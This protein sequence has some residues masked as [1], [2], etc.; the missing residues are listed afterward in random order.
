[1]GDEKNQAVSWFDLGYFS[2]QPGE[3]IKIITIVFLA[4]YYEKNKKLSLTI[5][6][7]FQYI[8]LVIQSS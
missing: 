7:H 4:D 5:H 3:F 6:Y 1:M 2:F 8:S